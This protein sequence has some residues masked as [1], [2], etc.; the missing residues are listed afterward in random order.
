MDPSEPPT[1]G[2]LVWYLY[3]NSTA[4]YT[5]P[6]C[7]WSET[8]DLAG[9]IA[10]FLGDDA[11]VREGKTWVLR[12]GMEDLA[13]LLGYSEEDA[14]AY[15]GLQDFALEYVF[16][17]DGS[18]TGS[19]LCLSA[20]EGWSPAM[21][22]AASWDSDRTGGTVEAEFHIKNQMKLLLTV[23]TATEETDRRPETQ[24]PE[25]AAALALEDLTGW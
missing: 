19:L 12:L 4:V 22:V 10:L 2:T 17:D 20:D 16:G 13:A 5:D 6:V 25:G 24:A 8:L 18:F 3:E 11:L 14:Y 23:T 7:Y 1:V 21:R 9:T 15:L